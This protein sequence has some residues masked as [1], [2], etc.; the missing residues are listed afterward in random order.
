MKRYVVCRPMIGGGGIREMRL[1]ES[2]SIDL[3]KKNLKDLRKAH[4]KQEYWIYDRKT[5]ERLY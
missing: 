4:P 3:P 2:D 1:T 5:G